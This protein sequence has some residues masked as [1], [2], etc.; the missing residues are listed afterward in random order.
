MAQNFIA[1]DREQ[2]FLMPPSLREWLPADH[3]AWF[4]LDAVA[5]LDLAAFYDDYR[6]DGHGRPAHDPA[7]MVALVLYAYAVGERS[8]RRIERRCREDV[9][10][11]VITGNLAPDHA[12]I[13]RFLVRH[14][15]RLEGLFGQVLA[16][17]ARS[18]LV[19][20]GVIAL[21]STKMHANAS[22]LA[23]LDYGQIARE[24]IA[25]GIATDAAED[26]LYG[27]ARGDE[28]PA[29]LADPRTRKARLRAAKEELEA[30]WEAERQAR[31]A[32]LDRR[33]EHER[34]TGRRPTGRPPAQ[35]DMSGDP[36]GR[37]NLTDP[38]SRPVK[39][40]RGYIQGYNA[41]AVA[42]AEQIIIAAD[43]TPGS[44][45]QGLLEPMITAARDQ[46]AAAGIQAGPERALADAGYW[47][48]TQIERLRSD[49]LSVLVPPDAH[50]RTGPP[51]ANKR[52]GL[53][54]QMRALLT[55]HAGR[56]LYHRRQAII[57]PIFGQTK[58]NRRADRFRRR[59]LPA[60]QAEW[61]LIT[62]THNLLKLWRATTA[63]AG[64]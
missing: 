61:R 5:E 47:S 20:A 48:G 33:A 45:D 62:A 9:A 46:L 43:V 36:P 25:E 22:G 54:A 59:G 49:G 14:Q 56:D 55:S 1:A 7:L 19:R 2:V 16:L 42:T 18:G 30:E 35:R 17:C 27:D 40:P 23:N 3:L 28:L 11:R 4:V 29:E 41:Q 60:V 39:T 34:R 38:D 58:F 44:A 24:I 37:V 32:M 15:D 63:P 64:A 57:E 6:A 13:A 26:E 50:T 21:D 53:A 10:F 52:G 51:A 12:T 8:T 31:Q